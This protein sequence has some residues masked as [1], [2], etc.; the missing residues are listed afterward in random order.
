MKTKV[1]Y[2]THRFQ[3]FG[4]CK[5]QSLDLKA[6]QEEKQKMDADPDQTT[7]EIQE[8]PNRGLLYCD[9]SVNTPGTYFLR[10]KAIKIGERHIDSRC[11]GTRSFYTMP[12]HEEEAKLEFDKAK[13]AQEKSADSYYSQPW[14]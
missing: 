10:G 14:V 13:K 8:T 12:E 2:F 1:F 9:H 7:S 5:T 3:N 11:T 4:V 6:L